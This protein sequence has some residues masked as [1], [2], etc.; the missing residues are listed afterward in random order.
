MPC[1]V[2]YRVV[3]VGSTAVIGA[4]DVVVGVVA[5]IVNLCV[6]QP[7]SLSS[8]SARSSRGSQALVLTTVGI[9]SPLFVVV[10]LA[11]AVHDCGVE[12]QV[13]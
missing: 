9:R 8:V 6:T 3:V 12:C 2:K 7:L 11:D 4:R 13:L 1:E 5:I 10:D